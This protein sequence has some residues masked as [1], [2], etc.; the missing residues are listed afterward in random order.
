MELN[1]L[2]FIPRRRS[3]YETFDL[4]VL[5]TKQ[6]FVPLFCLY[7][8]LALPV[9]VVAGIV[10]G[11]SYSA[12]IV[13]Y[14]KP[15]FERPILDYVSKVVFNQP[16]S[17]TN[18]LKSL[19]KLSLGDFLVNITIYRLSPN[20]AFL[21]PVTQLEGLEGARKERRKQ[22]L[23]ATSKPKQSLW[24]IFCVHFEFIL[25]MSISA[26]V[27]A[28]V[29]TSL[30]LEEPVYQ[31]LQTPMW[32]EVVFNCIYLLSITLVAPLFVTGGFMAYLHR[33]VD[34]EGWDIELAFKNMRSRITALTSCICLCLLCSFSLLPSKAHAEVID[35]TVIKKEVAELYAQDN[36]IETQ[37]SWLPDLTFEQDSSSSDFSWLKH[38]F[39]N[40]GTLL[41]YI[42][43]PLI[44]L[45]IAWLV[46]KLVKN[47]GYFYLTKERVKKNDP[48]EHVIPT[49]FSDV[50]Q[51]DLPDDLLVA[52]N[53]AYQNG[54]ER[55]A[56]AYLLQFSLG[57]A[58]TRYA[59]KLHHSMT[60]REC[61]IA[62]DTHVN[63]Q[64]GSVFSTLFTNWIN[65]AWGHKS[66]NFDFALLVNQIK[67]MTLASEDVSRET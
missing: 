11:W 4:S 49:L 32:I 51:H 61:K 34:L 42:I 8:C 21:A 37:T 15:L 31:L 48:P 59:I 24:M 22:V 57:W 52:A 35:K 53:I 2:S 43:W 39:S 20:R 12:F 47:R 23:F 16:A 1:Q 9:F 17:I 13:W 7:L 65:V 18:S 28:L 45:F 54:N 56:L 40:L 19:K 62:I 67:A 55:L 3:A 26:I 10:F 50:K 36:V 27:Y 44:G 29:P 30:T 58:Q 41:S 25:L 14:L 63:K 38:F 64:E 6:H 33:R 46:Y 60:E 5:F 66:A